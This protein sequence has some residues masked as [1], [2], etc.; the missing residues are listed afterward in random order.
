MTAGSVRKEKDMSSLEDLLVWVD[1][2]KMLQQNQKEQF[3][4][5]LKASS[6]QEQTRTRQEGNWK[7]LLTKHSKL[8]RRD[9]HNFSHGERDGL[10]Q[11]H[12]FKDQK[13]RGLSYNIHPLEKFSVSLLKIIVYIEV[14]ER[15]ANSRAQ[16]GLTDKVKTKKEKKRRTEESRKKQDSSVCSHSIQRQFFPT[17]HT[18][19]SQ[20]HGNIQAISR[21]KTGFKTIPEII[22]IE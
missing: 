10:T 9:H 5:G 7:E 21:F 12:F 18:Q 17:Y 20:Y 14:A 11:E 1:G 15:F 8:L 22:P 3:A 19:Y 16:Q 6:V 4:Q 13:T 2:E